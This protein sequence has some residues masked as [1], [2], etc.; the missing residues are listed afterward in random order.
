MR[1]HHLVVGTRAHMGH[2]TYSAYNLQHSTYSHTAISHTAYSMQY[3]IQHTCP[4]AD[5]LSHTHGSGVGHVTMAAVCRHVCVDCIWLNRSVNATMLQKREKSV[6]K[7]G[8]E[9]RMGGEKP[10]RATMAERGCGCHQQSFNVF[11]DAEDTR[12]SARCLLWM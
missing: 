7:V 2:M 4:C 9:R 6:N 8:R 11:N 1:N 5:V 12:R 3:S 10:R